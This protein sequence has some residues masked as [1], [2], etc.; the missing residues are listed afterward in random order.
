[1][2]HRGF[3]R[4]TRQ[5]VVL[6][7]A[8]CGAAIM[9]CRTAPTSSEVSNLDRL[10]PVGQPVPFELDKV[11]LPSYVI[12]P[13][14]VLLIESID[15]VPRPPYRLRALDV[16]NLQVL[17]TLPNLPIANSYAVEPSGSVNLGAPYGAVSIAGM[18][19]EEA[20]AAITQH[21]SKF[22]RDPTVSVSLA[23]ISAA[24]QVIGQYLVGP[25]GT[26]TL[27]S[28]GDVMV[29]GMT[30][31]HA[32]WAI[33]QHLSQ[34]LLSPEISLSVTSFNSKVY[35]LVL[36]GAGLGDGVYRFPVTGNET[37]L[38]AIAQVNGLN[39][40][41]SKKI[42]IAR[43]SRNGGP[44]KIL[45]VDWLAVTEQAR[46]DSNYQLLPG[47]RVFVREDKLV[48]TDVFLAKLF[49]PL[50]RVMGISLLGVG[51]ATRFSGNVLEG[52]GNAQSNF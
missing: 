25:D 26:V 22:L 10:P 20:Q 36:Q 31:Q 14:D 3:F 34:F 23:E 28:Y 1:M 6:T 45:P 18:T 2:S 51:T 21:L 29:V 33:E 42:W 4:T 24:Q 47:D 11:V 30:V 15:A 27:G 39:Q 17:G 44:A 38:D 50:E 8:L 13:P 9:G 43:P 16:V 37:V 48:A 19:V 7:A 49:S 5:H 40:V 46:V 12:E 35:Y 52:G 41:S 32:K